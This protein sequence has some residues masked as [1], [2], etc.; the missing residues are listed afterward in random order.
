MPR[1]TLCQKCGVVLNLPA[2]ITAGKKLKCPKCGNRFTATEADLNSNSSSRV[3]VDTALSATREMKKPPLTADERPVPNA[4][5]NLRERFSAPMGTGASVERSAAG[6]A[7]SA[8]SDA[9]ALFQDQPVRKKKSSAA[10]ARAQ[11]RRCLQCGGHVPIGM[12]TCVNCGVDQE[13]GMRVGQEDDLA[14]SPP[15][16]PEAPLH[17]SITGFLCGLAAVI[18]LILGLVQSIRTQAGVSRYGW[19]CLAVVS[20]LGIFGAVQFLKGRSAKQLMIAL[21]LGVLVNLAFLIAVP[22]YQANFSDEETALVRV[23]DKNHPGSY[24]DENIEIQPISERLDGERLTLG[25]IVILLYALLSVYLMSP[26]V[27]RYLARR[28]AAG[29]IRQ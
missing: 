19:M 22:I 13:T 14:P 3:A 23:K 25:F 11:A 21:T 6:G 8:S 5:S 26:S 4:E 24:D 27:K 20:S 15:P 12:S 9:E 28:A 1:T 7:V 18:L 17:V 16:P 2:S 10:Q 29:R